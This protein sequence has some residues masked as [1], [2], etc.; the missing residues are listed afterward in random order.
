[1]SGLLKAPRPTE[2]ISVRA[3]VVSRVSLDR[4]V[5]NDEADA[6]RSD[7]AGDPRLSA[8]LGHQRQGR[9]WVAA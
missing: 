5:P 6:D 3:K 4:M 7:G 9:H 8:E 1:M 2:R